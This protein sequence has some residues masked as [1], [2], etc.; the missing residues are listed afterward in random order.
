MPRYLIYGANGYTGALIA[1]EAVKRGQQPILAGRNHAALGPLAAELGLQAHVFGLDDSA[2]I[3][4]AL[5]DVGLVLHCAGPFSHTARAMADGCLRLR[6]HYLDITGEISVFEAMAAQDAEAKAAGVMLM[7]GVGFDVVPSDCLAAHLKRRLSS[8]TRLSL[9]LMLLSRPS[10]GTAMTMAE[11]LPGGGLIRR[12]GVLTPVPAA[13]KSRTIDFG[14][15]PVTAMTIPWGD[16]S[17]AYYST[18]IPNIEVYMAASRSLRVAARLSRYFG[19]LLGS[20]W[21]QRFLKKRIQGGSPGP[22]DEERARGHSFLWGE[23]TDDAGNRVVSR[24]RGPEGYIFT[25][26]TALAVV[27]RALAGDA[28]PGFQTPSKAYG[29]DFVLGIAGVSREDESPSQPAPRLRETGRHSRHDL[30]RARLARSHHIRF[31]E[32]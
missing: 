15:G 9:A 19:W 32:F 2:A 17:T 7:P 25:V 24:L 27:E 23:A 12:D 8:A 26:L 13:W 5:R 3:D 11:N 16:V 18:D 28:A 10:R 22:T 1:R 20:S 4:E 31:G 6:K 30:A 29:P 14:T 21:V